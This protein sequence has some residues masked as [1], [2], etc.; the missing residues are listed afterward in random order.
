MFY[1]FYFFKV[2]ISWICIKMFAFFVGFGVV[3]TQKAH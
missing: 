2:L 1:F 3:G